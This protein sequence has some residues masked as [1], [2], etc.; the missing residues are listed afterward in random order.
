MTKSSG[1]D[2]GDVGLVFAAYN[3]HT[4]HCGAPR[5]R[6][7]A[8]PDLYHGY[9][10]NR[11]GEQFVFTFD[12]A[13]KTG[14]VS[15][16]DLGWGIPSFTLAAIGCSPSQHPRDGRTARE[17]GTR[18]DAGP[19]RDRRRGLAS[20]AVHGSDRQRRDRLAA[21]VPG[22]LYRLPGTDDVLVVEIAPSKR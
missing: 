19:A 18:R 5:L 21:G 20:R 17:G 7:T 15:G 9:F 6:N 10:E 1:Q 3:A 12:R 11:Y 8:N 14:T 22:G 4:E 13:T 2:R 16:G